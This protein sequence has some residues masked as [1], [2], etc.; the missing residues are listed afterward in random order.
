MRYPDSGAKCS[1]VGCL[2][3]Q[4]LEV[5]GFLNMLEMGFRGL[6]F[7]RIIENREDRKF[8]LYEAVT[9]MDEAERLP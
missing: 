4:D 7:P 1:V 9:T 6:E 5:W 2:Q 3:G 8:S